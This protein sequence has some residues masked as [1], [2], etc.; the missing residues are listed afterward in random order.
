MWQSIALKQKQPHQKSTK[1]QAKFWRRQGELFK[2]LE[3]VD[4]D[5]W[6][7]ARKIIIKI[8]VAYHTLRVINVTSNVKLKLRYR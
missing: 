2:E 5:D 8:L 6:A 3:W 1:K 7:D 4:V